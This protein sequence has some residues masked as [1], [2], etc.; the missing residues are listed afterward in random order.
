MR[1]VV[2]GFARS[3]KNSRTLISTG[4]KGILMVSLP[5]VTRLQSGALAILFLCCRDYSADIC[6]ITPKKSRKGISDLTPGDAF[7]CLFLLCRD[8]SRKKKCLMTVIKINWADLFSPV[9]LPV[10]FPGF[11]ESFFLAGL[12][13]LLL[14]DKCEIPISKCLPQRGGHG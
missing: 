10:V 3:N 2:S 8:A 6:F 9:C 13:S 5:I 4:R 1:V 14:K 11:W 7:A 12:P